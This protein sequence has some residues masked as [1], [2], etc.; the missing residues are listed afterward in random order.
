MMPEHVNGD[1][2][3]GFRAARS[4]LRLGPY[5]AYLAEHIASRVER[6]LQKRDEGDVVG[7][8][9]EAGERAVSP[10]ARVPTRTS[11]PFEATAAVGMGNRLPERKA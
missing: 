10:L 11:S 8:V 4:R 9:P 2:V 6:L 7:D 5:E 3:N 1:I